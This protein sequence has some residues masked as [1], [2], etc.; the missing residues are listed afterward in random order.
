MTTRNINLMKKG[1]EKSTTVGFFVYGILR[2]YTLVMKL[3]CAYFK[4]FYC[5]C[6][7]ALKTNEF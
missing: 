4:F 7:S 1:W 3:K 2:N 6:Y 5:I